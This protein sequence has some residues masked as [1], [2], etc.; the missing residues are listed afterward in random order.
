VPDIETRNPK[1]PKRRPSPQKKLM[2]MMAEIAGS[3]SEQNSQL[4]REMSTMR[5]DMADI[6]GMLARF[7]PARSSRRGLFGRRR[8][9]PVEIEPETKTKGTLP[10]D[11]LLPLLPQLGNVIP[12]LKNPKM[13]ETLKVLSNPAVMGMIQQFLANGAFKRGAIKQVKGRRRA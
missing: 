6:K 11:E 1:T 9:I 3:T 7:K 12:Q 8:S 4:M 5:Q 10:L 2:Q 13:A